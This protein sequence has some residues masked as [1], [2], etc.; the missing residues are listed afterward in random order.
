MTITLQDVDS[1]MAGTSEIRSFHLPITRK[2]WMKSKNGHFVVVLE[3]GSLVIKLCLTNVT[4]QLRW[5]LALKPG[6][7]LSCA[8]ACA[9][10]T[11]NPELPNKPW[12][13][14]LP[15]PQPKAPPFKL[16]APP[17]SGA[18]GTTS[19]SMQRRQSVSLDGAPQFGTW[20]QPSRP[21]N[22]LPTPYIDDH[23]RQGSLL[24]SWPPKQFQAD[25]SLYLTP[26]RMYTRRSESMTSDE[27]MRILTNDESLPSHRQPQEPSMSQS[28][29]QH[30][31][32]H[33][34]PANLTEAPHT[35]LV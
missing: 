6:E 2:V 33:K 4:E 11:A 25:A 7:L 24:S 8:C 15:T 18:N 16:R 17:S 27:L 1:E 3:N 31:S 10:L 23:H 12:L 20:P 22:E 28:P 14:S 9:L 21:S 19:P 5:A 13:T 29:Q 34:R 35:T 26:S 32:A 30:H